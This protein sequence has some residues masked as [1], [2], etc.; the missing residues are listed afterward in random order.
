MN[1]PVYITTDSTC[2]L[3]PELLERFQIKTV[4]LHV[5]LGEE[6]YLDGVEFTPDM[7]Y[8]RYAKDKILP[9]TAAVSP[10]EFTEFFTPLVEAG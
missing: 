4:P 7:I 3:T 10:Q 2:D 8:E 6:V 5:V 1:K 9:R